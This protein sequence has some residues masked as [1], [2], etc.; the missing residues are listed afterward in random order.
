MSDFCVNDGTRFNSFGVCEQCG[1]TREKQDA[2]N[3]VPQTCITC[4]V[5]YNEYG[6]CPRCGGRAVA[7]SS[8][9]AVL[10]DYIR[11]FF[12]ARPMMIMDNSINTNRM[13]WPVI[14]GLAAIL[15]P[16]N[17][18]IGFNVGT[19]KA[20]YYIMFLIAVN[21]QFFAS[22]GLLRAFM[23]SAQE[24]PRFAALLNAT[25][26]ALLPLVLTSVVGAVFAFFLP[27]V[28]FALMLLGLC[29]SSIMLY[30][31]MQ[32][33]AKYTK[34]PFWSFFL[35]MAVDMTVFAAICY[36]IYLI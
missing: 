28:T 35:L 26:L 4:G 25:S 33:V 15:A 32:R 13:L 20:L 6:I 18:V 9:W 31:G 17:I 14:V 5:D 2:L 24:K 8:Y 23:R 12:S 7:A 3:A 21:A 10:F 30:Y 34:S 19:P 16:L 11:M 22:A 36:L 1:N 27:V 29:F